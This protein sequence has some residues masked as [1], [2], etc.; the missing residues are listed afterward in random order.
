MRLPDS[1]IWSLTAMA[2]LAASPAMA[3]RPAPVSPPPG[4]S[5]NGPSADYPVL[6][7]GSYTVGKTLFT[8][9]DT[10][11]YDA[12][13]YASIAAGE[14]A[15][16]AA[17]HH[18]LPVP[19]Y[20]EVTSLDSGRTI[21]VRITRRGPM[22]SAN[23]IEL[24]ASAAAQLGVGDHAGVRVRRVNPPEQERAQLRGGGPGPERM[25]TPKG[26]LAVL[27]RRLNPDGI[28]TLSGPADTPPGAAPIAPTAVVPA[29]APHSSPVVATPQ[30][31]PSHPVVPS[32][33]PKPAPKPAPPPPVAPTPPRPVAETPDP[34]AE[35]PAGKLVI[36]AG[37]FAV[38]ANADAVAA[39]IGGRVFR[40]GS[41]WRVQA[42]PYGNRA[43]AD[44]ALAKVR[45]AGYSQARIQH[46]E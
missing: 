33:K 28:V 29:P 4:A 40:A 18:T 23:L 27:T 32:P 21:V 6:V 25:A 46:A 13:G 42:G 1:R 2:V 38:K 37:A 34:V 9:A 35:T 10:M 36:Q 20:V 12:V 43:Q 39:R 5:V 24:S 16:V 22:D 30:A 7:G 17:G 3:G 8:P 44:A 41:L 15:L 26:L 19:S 45:A 14:G 31:G 11:N